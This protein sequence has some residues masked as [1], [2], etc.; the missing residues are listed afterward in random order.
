MKWSELKQEV[1]KEL[2]AKDLK[3][4]EIRDIDLNPEFEYVIFID[5]YGKLVIW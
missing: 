5:E 1:D 3:D 2:K 4:I